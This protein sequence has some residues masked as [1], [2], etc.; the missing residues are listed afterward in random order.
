V[1]LK[2]PTN[3][4]RCSNGGEER[5]AEPRLPGRKLHWSR[6]GDKRATEFEPQ[7]RTRNPA[8]AEVWIR[9][10]KGKTLFDM[11]EAQTRE[12]GSLTR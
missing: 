5:S 4:T 12:G 9:R 1:E 8:T 3:K 7:K 10:G 6:K 2:H 11:V